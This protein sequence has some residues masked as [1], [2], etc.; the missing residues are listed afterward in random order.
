MGIAASRLPE[1]VHTNMLLWQQAVLPKKCITVVEWESDVIGK[2]RCIPPLFLPLFFLSTCGSLLT[3]AL[4]TWVIVSVLYILS[5]VGGRL[6]TVIHR[7]LDV[8]IGIMA[9]AR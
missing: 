3:A 1:E 7:F 5:I 6:Y 2:C 9:S 4:A 8:F